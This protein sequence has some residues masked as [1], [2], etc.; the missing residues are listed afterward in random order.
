MNNEIESWSD[1]SQ[2]KKMTELWDNEADEIWEN[3]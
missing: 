3:A 2:S 1:V